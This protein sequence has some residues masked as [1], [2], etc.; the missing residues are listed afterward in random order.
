MSGVT[1]VPAEAIEA[2]RRAVVAEGLSGPYKGWPTP[3]SWAA[4]RYASAVLAAALPFLREGITAEVLGPV[5][6]ILDDYSPDPRTNSA[7]AVCGRIRAALPAP[8]QAADPCRE[9]GPGYRIG[10]E[11][12]RHKSVQAAEPVTHEWAGDVR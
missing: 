2:G 7:A 9:C 11:G 6:E 3:P 12:C 5:R 8:V 4:E 1:G 10:D